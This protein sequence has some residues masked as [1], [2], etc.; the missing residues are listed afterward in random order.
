VNERRVLLG[1][2][3]GG[4]PTAPFIASLSRLKLPLNV[5]SIKR[6][7]AIGN[8]IPGQRELIMSDAI[9]EGFDYLLFVDDDVV[10][11]EDALEKLIATAESDPK[12]AVVGALYYSRDSARPIAVAD[13]NSSDTSSAHIPAFTSWSTSVVD[14]IGFGCA[15]LRVSVAKELGAPYFPAH[16][17]I[18]RS[19]RRVRQCDEDYLYC[20]RVRKAGYVVRLD[21][22]VRCPHYDRE[23]DST[24]PVMWE[25]DAQTSMA[26]MIV[27]EGEVTKLVPLDPS[28][29]RIVEHHAPATVTYITVD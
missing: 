19:A 28:V 2:A 25:T 24:A 6:S 18:E 14:G 13:W 9:A 26:R 23:S 7:V 17:Y 12:T 16:I 10:L 3:S 29:P 8:Y 20:E 4:K 11:P 5:A 27:L 1:V 21:A 22:R 15:L